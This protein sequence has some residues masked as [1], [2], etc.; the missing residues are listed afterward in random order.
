MRLLLLTFALIASNGVNTATTIG[1]FPL[2]QAASQQKSATDEL[3]QSA[4]Q[5]EE[6]ELPKVLIIGDSISIGYTPLVSTSL[7]GKA[8]VRHNPGNAQHTSNGLEMLDKWIG[9]EEW[10]VI[11]FNWGLWDLCYRHPKSKA[12]GKRDKIRGTLT[13]SVEQYEQNLDELV[14]RLKETKAKLIW[15]HTTTVPE[16]E[17]GRKLG[18]DTLY[19]EAAARVMEK[20]GILVNDLNTLSDSFEAEL[21]VGPGNVHFTTEGSS[22]LAEAVADSILSAIADE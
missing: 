2:V 11:H 1:A 12:Q 16:G 5:E 6:S 17:A 19:N 8:I 15:A 14:T 9:D 4:V 21:Y 7:D 10:D 3:R 20:H 18:D 13:T 22:R